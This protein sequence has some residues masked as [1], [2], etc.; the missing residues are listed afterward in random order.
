MSEQHKPKL[1][2]HACCGVCSAYV[3]ELLIPD[4]DVTI[5]YENSNIYPSEEFRRRADATREMAKRYGIPFIEISQDEPSWYRSVQ[6]HSQERENGERCQK[7]MAF[8][9]DHAFA[10]AKEHGFSV[11]A[12]TLGVS[13][14]KKI[15]M[16]HGIGR[17]LSEK[18]GIS[19]LERDWKKGGGEDESQRRAKE[20][21]IYRQEY[22]GC[23]YSKVRKERRRGEV[24]SSSS[25]S[26]LAAAC[27]AVA[28]TFGVGCSRQ[29][30]TT[31]IIGSILPNPFTA[32][33][34]RSE[35]SESFAWKPVAE[36]AD[37]ATLVIPQGDW[38][39]TL[40]VYRFDPLKYRFQ[41]ANSQT[42]KSIRAW[43]DDLSS[44]RF[45]INGVY[46]HEDGTPSG[47]LRINGADISS[48]AFDA[49]KSGLIVLDGAPKI[50]DTSADPDISGSTSSS[51]QSYPFLI[52][53]GVASVK[54]DSG[55]LARRSFI[56]TDKD[57]LV[58][59]GVYTDGEQSLYDFSKTLEKLPITWK[60]ALNLDGGPSTSFVSKFSGAEDIEDGYGSI[61]NVIAVTER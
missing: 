26:I 51:A 41:F 3:P 59:L 13:R 32:T 1:L 9:L 25:V 7:C 20:A 60:Y 30:A 39:S 12:C 2:L 55:L 14:R 48:R 27:I 34:T 31:P 15:D 17:A 18:Y 19:F 38:K 28:M 61:P 10:Y 57:G 36:G 54:E 44:V 35:A 4:Y 46:F 21:G 50:V 43:R 11:V 42:P 56:G 49:D 29:N 16:V 22:C 6:G 58:Y 37:R 8:R 47:A 45:I 53:D 40:I 5:Y 52:K 23:V 33:S 24:S